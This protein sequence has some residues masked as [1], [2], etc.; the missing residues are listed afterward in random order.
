VTKLTRRK[1]IYGSLSAVGIVTLASCAG[2]RSAVT[3]QKPSTLLAAPTYVLVHGAWHGGWC[4]REIR[5][6]LQASGAKVF[7]PTLTGLGERAHLAA[8]HEVGL[9]THIQDVVK[10]IE[11]E[12]LTNVILVGHSYGGMVITGV[13]DKIGNKISELIYLDALVPK[14]NGSLIDLDNM[15]SDQQVAETVVAL[16]SNKSGMLPVPELGFLD[17]DPADAK[18]MWVKRRMTPHPIKTLV[19]RLSFDTDAHAAIK[20][21]YIMCDWQ[22]RKDKDRERI[23][24][25]TAEPNWSLHELA[26]GHDAMVTEPEKL[27]ALFAKIVN[28]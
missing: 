28:A 1:F 3:D 2:A 20:K 16:D 7:T 9:Q 22:T 5:K 19:D 17:L 11:Y 26:A 23:V 13:A 15:L 6:L 12:E 27:A 25:F 8:L 14:T 18:G 4:W 24:N 21:A 10:L